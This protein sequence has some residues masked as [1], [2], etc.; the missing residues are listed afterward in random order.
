M[1]SITEAICAA[2]GPA[3]VTFAPR[4]L[5]SYTTPNFF[6][7]EAA[8]ALREASHS[9]AAFAKDFAADTAGAQSTHS[10]HAQ[11]NSMPSLLSADKHPLPSQSPQ[12]FPSGGEQ[13]GDPPAKRRSRE[14]Q[15]TQKA[16]EAGLAPALAGQQGQSSPTSGVRPMQDAQHTKQSAQSQAGMSLSTG[17]RA[18]HL[19][20]GMPVQ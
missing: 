20:A 18:Q 5:A 14:R 4:H 7:G 3:G 9:G 15:P 17:V 10:P 12:V 11:S 6:S 19:H 1:V 13:N 8:S 16:I 2:Q